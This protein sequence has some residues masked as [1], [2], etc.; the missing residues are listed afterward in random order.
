MRNNEYQINSINQCIE[1]FRK[2]QRVT[3]YRVV[4]APFNIVFLH[5]GESSVF[6]GRLV[7]TEK[8]KFYLSTIGDD[9]KQLQK[10]RRDTKTSCILIIKFSGEKPRKANWTVIEIKDSMPL[11][12]YRNYTS[13]IDY[14][15]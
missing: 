4:G 2:E 11:Y 8:N 14:V 3:G 12:I 5:D 15:E 9:I 10:I 13:A 1:K 7:C 6:L